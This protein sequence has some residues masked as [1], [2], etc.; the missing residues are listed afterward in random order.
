MSE[1]TAGGARAQY[2]RTTRVEEVAVVVTERLEMCGSCRFYDPTGG[3]TGLCR[4]LAPTWRLDASRS[5]WP[6][7]SA[8]DWCGEF[9]I[10]REAAR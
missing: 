9:R 10:P 1:D 3:T 5:E 6:R 8:T 4:R 2:R 7:V